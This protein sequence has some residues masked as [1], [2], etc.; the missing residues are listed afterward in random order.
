LT[1]SPKLVAILCCTG[2]LARGQDDPKEFFEKHV[3]PLLAARCYGC[4]SA[5]G[6]GG[7][8]ADSRAALLKGGKSGAAI[9]PGKP[10]ESLLIRR[11][12]QDDAQ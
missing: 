9:V 1:S 11:I 5:E 3:R 6:R 2:A 4:H 12:T 10:A 7:L 8:R